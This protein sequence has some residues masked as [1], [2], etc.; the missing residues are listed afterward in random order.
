MKEVQST[1]I[2]WPKWEHTWSYNKVRELDINRIVHYE[3]VPTGQTVDH[4]YYLEVLKRLHEKIRWKRPELFAN[5]SW[6]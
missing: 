6:I 5:N 3:L 2:T 4:V 1:S